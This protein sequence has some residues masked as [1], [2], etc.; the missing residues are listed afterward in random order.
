MIK[1]FLVDD[2]GLI[3]FGMRELLERSE[4]V[5]VVGEAEDGWAALHALVDQEQEVD[6]V[7]LDLS[8][9]RLSGTEL[10][11]RLLD[12]RPG[13][14]VLVVSMYSEE[15]FGRAVVSLGAAGYLTKDR[16]DRHLLQAVRTVARGRLF[17]TRDTAV[18][19][20]EGD[21]APHHHL[22]AREIQVF[23]L[24]AEGR[25]VGDIAAE[26][27]VG[28]STISTY[29]GRIRTKL[30]VD[31]IAGIVRYAFLHGLIS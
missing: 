4:D 17:I 23:M 24:L 13:L 20:H 21:G 8:M 7:I 14:R 10:L 18:G 27:G 26:L 2:H 15:Q 22:A 16:A 25:Q 1:V 31:S 11:R 6:V 19:L 29:V 9:P 12:A 28:V 3:R 5:E 30:G